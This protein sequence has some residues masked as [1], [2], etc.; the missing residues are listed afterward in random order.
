MMMGVTDRGEAQERRT[1]LRRMRT[2][3][4]GIALAFGALVLAACG[5]S[6]TV[7]PEAQ[8]AATTP[9]TTSAP[10]ATQP[11]ATNPPATAP[12]TTLP[13]EPV[14]ATT[15]TVA[16]PAST[17][18]LPTIALEHS[19]PIQGVASEPITPPADAW[20]EE[21]IVELG[22][23]SIPKI[24]VEMTM[25]EGIRLSTLERGPGHWPGSAMPGQVGN[26]VVGGHRV[27]SHAVFRH[28]DQLAAGDEIVFED[29]TGRHVYLVRDVQIIDPYDVWIVDP[30]ETPTATLFA[31]HPP[32]STAQRIAI[33]ADLADG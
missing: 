33:F 20:A 7:E 8:P 4:G 9:V 16:A 29:E 25:Y 26:V 3:R 17:E 15:T 5:G 18:P 24:D 14:E 2:R 21:P 22:T 19:D 13:V 31:C 23:I 32:G 11:P 30:T 1:D 6:T 27:S 28:V 12:A 10:A